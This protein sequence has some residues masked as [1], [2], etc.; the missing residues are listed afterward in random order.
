MDIESRKKLLVS[1]C[2]SMIAEVVD[3]TGRNDWESFDLDSLNVDDL[4]EIRKNL[5]EILYAPPPRGR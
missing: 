2:R 1:Q 3:R 4:S 5:H